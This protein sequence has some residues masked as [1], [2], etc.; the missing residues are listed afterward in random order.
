MNANDSN[1]STGNDSTFVYL[2][3]V[4][5]TLG[6]LSLYLALSVRQLIPL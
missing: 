4:A 6:L 5:F 2:S 1:R 3:T